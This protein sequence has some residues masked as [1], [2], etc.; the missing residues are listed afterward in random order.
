MEFDLNKSLEILQGTPYV[1]EKQLCGLS[2]EWLMQNEGE[3]TWNSAEIVCHLIQ[4][5]EEDWIAR[6]KI[7][8]NEEG[9]KKFM[10]FNRTKGFEK[11]KEKTITELVSEFRMLRKENLEYLESHM[12]TGSDLDKTGVHPDFGEVTLKQLLATWVVHDLSHISQ[13]NRILAKQ[14]REEVGPW[15]EYLQVLKK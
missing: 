15:I 12:L 11:S 9:N 10:D 7:I 4:C 8:L 1:L 6:M 14:Y 5:E 3:G 13:I 2:R